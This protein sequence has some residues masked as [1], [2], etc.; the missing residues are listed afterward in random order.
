MFYH[1]GNTVSDY[2]VLPVNLS[3][4][5]DTEH[6]MSSHFQY[7]CIRH[8]EKA[9]RRLIEFKLGNTLCPF[10]QSW[11]GNSVHRGQ[12]ISYQILY[13]HWRVLLIHKQ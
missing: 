1:L 5:W 13:T 4:H 6:A 8:D 9:S 7:P 2:L 11:N 3:G 12:H 10:C